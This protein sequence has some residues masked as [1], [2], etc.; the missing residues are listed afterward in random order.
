MPKQDDLSALPA[1]FGPDLAA[2]HLNLSRSGFYALARRDELPIPVVRVGSRIMVRRCD[3]FGFL[4]IA[5]PA[6]VPAA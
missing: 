3:L 1:L 2:P 5:D 4:G 6:A